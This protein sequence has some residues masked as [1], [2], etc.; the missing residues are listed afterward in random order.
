MFLL[1]R[2]NM[3]PECLLKSLLSGGTLN[4]P[5]MIIDSS[6]V[7]QIRSGC[8]QIFPCEK[9]SSYITAFSLQFRSYR[10]TP[11]KDQLIRPNL[12]FSRCCLVVNRD[13]ELLVL[14][15]NRHVPPHLPLGFRRFHCQAK[16]DVK[17]SFQYLLE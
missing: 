13:R 7:E 15:N 1:D 11:I 10:K 16:N 4:K 9:R 6:K 14:R 2:A 12:Q 3:W 17:V 8:E 5:S